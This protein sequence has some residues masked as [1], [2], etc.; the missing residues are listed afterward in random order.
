MA[1]KRIGQFITRPRRGPAEVPFF[2]T[3][4]PLFVGSPASI[5]RIGVLRRNSARAINAIIVSEDTRAVRNLGS[6]ISRFDRRAATMLGR[7]LS[8][9]GLIILAGTSVRR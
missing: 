1:N 3:F 6:E 9:T 7:Q 5:E 8:R 4:F 2:L